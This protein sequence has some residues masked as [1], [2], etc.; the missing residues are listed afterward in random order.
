MKVGRLHILLHPCFGFYSEHIE[1]E[2]PLTAQDRVMG[3]RLLEVY[4]GKID[5]LG[6]EDV[7]AVFSPSREREYKDDYR[8]KRV[9]TEVENYAKERL[10]GRRLIVLPSPSFLFDDNDMSSISM[11]KT[12]LAKR[13]LGISPETPCEIW[14]ES[15]SACILETVGP[16][17]EGLGLRKITIPLK[18]TD[19]I[20]RGK[21]LES[22]T[23]LLKGKIPNTRAIIVDRP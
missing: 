14:G 4:K 20:D 12:E 8:R 17:E 7:L 3:E 1:P 21:E 23:R 6:Q 11:L 10:G 19:G 5:F 2:A 9:W 13:D 22:L 16:V 15:I 18:A